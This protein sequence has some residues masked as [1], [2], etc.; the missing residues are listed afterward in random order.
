[1]IINHAYNHFQYYYHR[2]FR[3]LGLEPTDIKNRDDLKRLP[4]LS[5]DIVRKE[6][7]N[8]IADN[9][10]QY[11]PLVYKT[12]GT[13]GT[14]VEIYLDKNTNILEFFIIGGIGVGPDSSLEIVLQS[15]EAFTFCN[16]IISPKQ[17]IHGNHI[18]EG[19]C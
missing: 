9:A 3:K 2:L 11:N 17:P 4:R 18:S 19:L 6:R 5:K 8:L 10:K 1:M 7:A 15:W 13:T 12:S 16:A 14:P